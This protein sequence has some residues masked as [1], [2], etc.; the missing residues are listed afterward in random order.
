[1]RSHVLLFTTSLLQL[2]IPSVIFIVSFPFEKGLYQNI[3]AV[4]FSVQILLYVLVSIFCRIVIS[5]SVCQC[6]IFKDKF[7]SQPL[8]LSPVRGFTLVN[9]RLACKY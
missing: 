2:N 8:V 1:M 4:I 5:W 7:G 6:Q 3:T 9:S